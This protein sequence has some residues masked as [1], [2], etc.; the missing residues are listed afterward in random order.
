MLYAGHASVGYGQP[1]GNKQCKGVRTRVSLTVLGF[2][3]GASM[4]EAL[5]TALVP[6]LN[7]N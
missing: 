6:V 1:Q 2:C 5:Y 7:S 3:V 4:E